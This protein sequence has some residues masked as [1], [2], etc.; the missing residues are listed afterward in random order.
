MIGKF[1]SSFIA[2]N[3]GFLIYPRKNFSLPFCKQHL[4][5]KTL[6]EKIYIYMLVLSSV[7]Y[8]Y[9]LDT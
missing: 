2:L 1:E 9:V 3:I 8:M 6:I 7:M 5:S 4:L